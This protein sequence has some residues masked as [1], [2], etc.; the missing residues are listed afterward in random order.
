[1]DA[2]PEKKIAT[3]NTRIHPRL[4]ARIAA[5]E[6]RHGVPAAV[7]IEDSMTALCD[8]VEISGVYRR[9]MYIVF[10]PLG[11]ACESVRLT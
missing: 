5:V 9:P 6:A 11:T 8:A 3:L 4:K 2:L 10:S 1:M 7:M